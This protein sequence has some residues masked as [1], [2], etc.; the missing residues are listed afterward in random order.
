LREVIKATKRIY[1]NKLIAKSN[2]KSKT[3]WSTVNNVTGKHKNT[4]DL[5]LLI[6]N[7]VKCKDSQ[8]TAETFNSYFDTMT[9]KELSNEDITSN[10]ISSNNNYRHYLSSIPIGHINDITYEPITSKELN[11]IIKSLFQWV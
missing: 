9:F 5:P 4:Y 3:V 6:V 8:N 1:Y 10:L 2:N 11:D 7:G